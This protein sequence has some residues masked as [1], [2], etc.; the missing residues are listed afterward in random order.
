MTTHPSLQFNNVTARH[1]E[2]DLGL[3]LSNKMSF[4]DCKSN[5]TTKT[6]KDTEV[7]HKL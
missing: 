3:Q 7:F 5:N 4:R 1:A 2:K 6:T